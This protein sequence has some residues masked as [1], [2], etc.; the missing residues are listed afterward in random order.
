MI[1]QK[2]TL[3]LII[4]ILSLSLINNFF[5]IGLVVKTNRIARRMNATDTPPQKMVIQAKIQ[6]MNQKKSKQ[7]NVPENKVS[8]EPETLNVDEVIKE[9]T[10]V[11]V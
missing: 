4:A 9:L 2:T 10:E 7:G 6:G 11:E 5:C 8:N 1:N 3:Y